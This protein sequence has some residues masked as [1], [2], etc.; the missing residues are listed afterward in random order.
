MIAPDLATLAVAVDSLALLPGNPRRGDVGAVAR[1]LAQFGQRKPIVARRDGTVI[2]GN[3]TL[4][5][6]QQLGWP[7]VAV[8]WVDD[9]DAT[10]SAFALADNRTAELGGYDDQ[11]LADLIA[12]VQAAD[13][14]LLAATGW[15]DADLEALLEDIAATGPLPTIDDPDAVPD[16]AP[17]KT[18]PGDVWLL[19][20]HR[21]MCGDSTVPTDVDRLMAGELADMVWTDPPYNVAVKGLAGS[22]MNDDLSA[23]DFASLLDGAMQSAFAALRPGGPI[24]VA[25]AE[26]E[27]LE[28]SRAFVDAGFKMSGC[29]VWRK[30]AFTLSRSDYQ[31]QHEPILYGWKP[32]AAHR[33]F[34]GRK[35]TS[36]VEATEAPF[37]QQPDGSWQ[38]VIGDRVF[39]LTGQD[40]AVTTLEGSTPEYPKPA[41]SEL[42]PTTKPVA[43]VQRQIESSSRH[44]NSVLD[45]FGGSG[46]TMIA[47]HLLG[48]RARL[49]ELDPK[50]CD[51]ICKR[52]QQAT[53]IIPI[54]ESTN[55]PHSFL[56]ADDEPATRTRKATRKPR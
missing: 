27:R 54:A 37:Q 42:H 20:G 7:E 10:A 50:Y 47:S 4:Q 1:S 29:I 40:I 38:F 9:D 41:R 15:S 35:Q 55:N 33:W 51:V 56:E 31:W 11:A 3:H 16:S 25:H 28:F 34:G 18:V 12:E 46:T 53:G 2:A 44:G 22:I 43:L 8:V 24:Y 13:A 5:A 30:N 17:A 23:G 6:A 21:L 39:V 14:D 49:M 52:F 19:D 45:L 32:G 26:T 36:I 48:R